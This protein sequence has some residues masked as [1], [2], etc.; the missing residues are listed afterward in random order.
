MTQ[1]FTVLGNKETNEFK[2]EF[3][4]TGLVSNLL[5]T[6]FDTTPDYADLN[7]EYPDE[8]LVNNETKLRKAVDLLIGGLKPDELYP[9]GH[10]MEDMI[11]ACYWKGLDCKDG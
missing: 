9:N 5:A 4:H 3:D 2:S 11:Q 1:N 6:G 8:T 10:S 7:E